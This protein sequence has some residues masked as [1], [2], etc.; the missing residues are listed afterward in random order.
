M[1]LCFFLQTGDLTQ[2]NSG[3]DLITQKADTNGQRLVNSTPAEVSSAPIPTQTPSPKKALDQRPHKK[4]KKKHLVRQGTS[5]HLSSKILFGASVKLQKKKKHKRTKPCKSGIKNLSQED[6][7]NG[8]CIHTDLGPS[9]S[10]KLR[11]IIPLDGCAHSRRKGVSGTKSSKK[12]VDKVAKN[13]E[14]NSNGDV[15]MVDKDFRERNGQNGA[16]LAA[17]VQ[18]KL[19]ST[20]SAGNQVDGREVNGSNDGRNDSTQNGLMS[21]LTRGLEETIGE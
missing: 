9:T 11:A 19:T 17:V 1:D 7:L 16:V 21:M 10:E 14:T 4:H 15:L 5:M 13:A 20:V 8:D 2:K 3:G 6:L 18:Q 12:K